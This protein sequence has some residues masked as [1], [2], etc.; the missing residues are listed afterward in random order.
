MGLEF[1]HDGFGV[2]ALG[3]GGKVEELG[4]VVAL[5]AWGE[6]GGE[7]LGMGG[8]DGFVEG[9]ASGTNGDKGISK[10]LAAVGSLPETAE[11]GDETGLGNRG[12][13]L[14]HLDVLLEGDVDDLLHE[15]HAEILQLFLV[16]DEDLDV[17]MGKVHAEVTDALLLV[18][19]GGLQELK[20][21]VDGEGALKAHFTEAEQARQLESSGSHGEVH[22]SHRFKFIDVDVIGIYVIESELERIAINDLDMSNMKVGKV[23]GDRGVFGLLT[24][25]Q[26]T[27]LLGNK[28]MELGTAEI[29]NERMSK[30]LFTS[31]QY[32]S[33]IRK[34]A[35]FSTKCNFM[36]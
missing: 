15:L 32:K 21:V 29:Q 19:M 12:L 16:R 11:V 10:L 9:D 13:V 2:L 18:L 33:N 28:F 5:P 26:R 35:Q 20:D 27:S 14:G 31:S 17:A 7:A 23:N 3:R 6:D 24:F 8:E 1:E 4:E 22:D 36:C 25:L 30:K 34:L